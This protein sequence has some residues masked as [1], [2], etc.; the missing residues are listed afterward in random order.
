M[1]EAEHSAPIDTSKDVLPATLMQPWPQAQGLQTL[2][3]TQLDV[4]GQQGL[5]TV[6][7]VIY[8]HQHYVNGIKIPVPII[9]V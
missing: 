3:M 9:M 8:I 4:N 1:Y 5:V 6:G 7:T 2:W